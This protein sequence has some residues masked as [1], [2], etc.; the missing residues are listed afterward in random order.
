MSLSYL[1]VFIRSTQRQG[2]HEQLGSGYQG[3]REAFLRT[4]VPSEEDRR[5]YTTAPAAGYRWFRSANVIPIEQWRRRQQA[6]DDGPSTTDAAT[7]P[8]RCHAWCMSSWPKPP[9]CATAGKVIIPTR[10][11]V[12]LICRLSMK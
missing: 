4:V 3:H 11:R 1:I 12:R 2:G 7:P 9:T 5:R 10:S 6:D 8:S